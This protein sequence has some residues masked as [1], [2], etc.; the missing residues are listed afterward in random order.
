MTQN[1]FKYMEEITWETETHIKDKALIDFLNSLKSKKLRRILRYYLEE[2]NY[3]ERY[4]LEDLKRDFY[5]YLKEDTEKHFL[6]DLNDR[7][8]DIM[9]LLLG[10]G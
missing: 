3:W 6:P 5:K 7:L 9:I 10:K 2:R 8:E 1:D 4:N